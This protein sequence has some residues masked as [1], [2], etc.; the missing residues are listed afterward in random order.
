MPRHGG[1]GM[2]IDRFIMN[3]FNISIKE[4]QFIFRGPNNLNP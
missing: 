1:F 3:I 4:A 2:G